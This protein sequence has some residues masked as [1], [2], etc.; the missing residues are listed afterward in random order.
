MKHHT[1]SETRKRLAEVIDEAARDHVPVLIT[2]GA[3]KPAAVLM[4]LEDFASY[5]ETQYLLA[6]PKNA[7][8]LLAAIGELEGGGGRERE[9]I[10][11]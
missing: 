4:S 7:E 3:G 8:R 11:E 5:Q 2:R 10:D 1:I 9:L 6:S